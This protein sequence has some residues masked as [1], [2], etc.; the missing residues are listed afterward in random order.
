MKQKKLIKG[1]LITIV[2]LT[3]IVILASCGFGGNNNNNT[4]TTIR[5]TIVDASGFTAS[6]F[7]NDSTMTFKIPTKVP[8]KIGCTFDAWYLDSEFKTK[9]VAGT[10]L[11]AKDYSI[12]AHYVKATYNVTIKDEGASDLVVKVEDGKQLQINTPTKDWYQFAG[13]YLDSNFDQKFELETRI[14]Q[15]YTLYTKWEIANY[16]INY[17]IEEDEG[18]INDDN[19][20]TFNK[21][22]NVTLLNAPNKEGFEFE[23]W[24]LDSEYQNMI[25]KI[26]TT[27]IS[28]KKL[29]IYAKFLCT[30]SKLIAEENKSSILL[31][32][33]KINVSASTTEADLYDY[34]TTS[35]RAT[36]EIRDEE[37]NKVDGIS[38]SVN[39]SEITNNHYTFTIKVISEDKQNNTTYTLLIT[40]YST[41]TAILY[42]YVGDDL[43]SQAEY[44]RGQLVELKDSANSTKNY[45]EFAY[46]TSDKANHNRIEDTFTIE[47]DTN[48]YAYFAPCKYEISYYVGL[49]ENDAN[50]PDEYTYSETDEL[51]LFP[52]DINQYID[53]MVFNGWYTE[54]GTLMNSIP[55]GTHD[56]VKLYAHYDIDLST[57]WDKAIEEYEKQKDSIDFGTETYFTVEI[58]K[59]EY[60][61]FV[62]FCAITSLTDDRASK[63]VVKITSTS[64]GVPLLVDDGKGGKEVNKVVKDYITGSCSVEGL[65]VGMGFSYSFSATSE[66]LTVTTTINVNDFALN[67]SSQ[68]KLNK[69][70]FNKFV[71]AESNKNTVINALDYIT[72]QFNVGTSEELYYYVSKG[73]NVKPIANSKAATIYNACKNVLKEIISND[74][75]D[76][77]KVVA[78]AQWIVEN[79]TYDYAAAN[80][81][82]ENQ[83]AFDAFYLDGVFIDGRAVCQGIAKSVTVLCMMEGIYCVDVT[84]VYQGVG[85]QWNKVYLDADL[86]GNKEWLTIDVTQCNVGLTK[87][88]SINSEFM[89]YLKMF[90]DDNEFLGSNY[91]Y[92]EQFY[93][94]EDIINESVSGINIYTLYTY[95]VDEVEYDYYIES[96][97]ELI[98]LFKYL[99]DKLKSQNNTINFGV[100]AGYASI[101]KDDLDA[102]FTSAGINIDTYSYTSGTLTNNSDGRTRTSFNVFFDVK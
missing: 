51:I 21:D 13:Y 16:E 55:A 30:E 63:F 70:S 59:E 32:I 100:S 72:T 62:N 47:E 45:Y 48:V 8:T 4:E 28:A 3:S 66:L 102:A 95:T 96:K 65:S 46:W 12:Y 52:A 76:R 91:T 24:Y 99:K 41:S 22:T 35:K 39:D 80:Y 64:F 77:D 43:D 86:D 36:I 40:Q 78:I 19:P 2:L 26:E 67:S 94:N 49:G 1:L 37:G 15:A 74:M 5:I 90:A 18:L 81:T 87:N 44:N 92:D 61:D 29:D 57:G 14:K 10:K 101:V 31:N 60:N 27:S 42:Y 25:T 23:G 38:F 58:E 85:H 97:A 83:G 79:V 69:Y 7:V 6:D 50:N 33:A 34:F 75:C 68:T 17:I 82:G 53:G 9:L 98:T 84:G 54:N 88:G 73:I 11:E 93:N 56:A 71:E 20:K 89:S